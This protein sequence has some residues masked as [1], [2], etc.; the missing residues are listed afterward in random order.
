MLKPHDFNSIS[1]LNAPTTHAA[2]RT[3]PHAEDLSGGIR[4]QWH[5][6]CFGASY[7]IAQ[8]PRRGNAK[9]QYVPRSACMATECA[10][11]QANFCDPNVPAMHDSLTADT[12]D[13]EAPAQLLCTQP[14]NYVPQKLCRPERA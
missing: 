10:A 4:R 5:R 1:S 7:S 8:K 3:T 9:R 13:V 11:A 12:P 2:Q 14:Y 6:P